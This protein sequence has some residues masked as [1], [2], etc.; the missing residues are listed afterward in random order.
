[1]LQLL[2]DA[3]AV[4]LRACDER[5]EE[6]RCLR[7][8]FD[9]AALT[10]VP[11]RDLL[12]LPEDAGLQ[13]IC[14]VLGILAME[15][16]SYLVLILDQRHVATIGDDGKVWQLLRVVLLPLHHDRCVAALSAVKDASPPKKGAENGSHVSVLRKAA[17]SVAH[18]VQTTITGSLE[19]SLGSLGLIKQQHATIERAVV[20]EL[21]RTLSSGTFYVSYNADI[22][23]SLGHRTRDETLSWDKLEQK[24]VWNM[25]LA[26]PFLQASLG[27]WV[28]PVVQGYFETVPC[29]VDSITFNLSLCSRRSRERAGFRYQR[30]G[31]DANN[32]NANFVETEQILAV[33]INGQQ[34][35]MC[36]LQVR[37]SIPLFWS[38][39]ARSLKPLPV[40]E[41]SA[42]EN[43]DAMKHHFRRLAKE[44]DGPVRAINLV[45]T[46]G[47]EAVIGSAYRETLGECAMD[48]VQ[49]IEFDFHHE[50]RGMLFGNVQRLVSRLEQDLEQIGYL[51]V[52]GAGNVLCRQQGIMRSNCMD[53]LDR[54]NVVQSALARH[55]IGLQ[56]M[57]LGILA[58]KDPRQGSFEQTFNILWANNGDKIAEAYTGTGALKGDFT[59]TGMR[60]LRGVA[61]DASNSL[62]RYYV[63]NF[64]DAYRQDV[65]DV[66]LG[67]KP[68][69]ELYVSPAK[70]T[71]DVEE[72]DSTARCRDAALDAAEYVLW[73]AESNLGAWIVAELS[74]EKG[75]DPD[76]PEKVMVLSDKALYLC[77]YNYAKEYIETSTRV[78]YT[79]VV[80]LQRGYA[81]D[82]G[83]RRESAGPMCIRV[84][85]QNTDAAAKAKE[86]VL[87]ILYTTPLSLSPPDQS[88]LPVRV[89]DITSAA[90]SPS[91]ATGTELDHERRGHSTAQVNLVLQLVREQIRA[92]TR[93][94]QDILLDEDIILP[95]SIKAQS[96]SKS[97]FPAIPIKS[98]ITGLVSSLSLRPS[99]AK[100][101]SDTP[102]SS[103]SASASRPS[104][105]QDVIQMKSVGTGSGPV[106]IAWRTARHASTQADALA[107]LRLLS[108]LK[109]Q[110]PYSLLGVAPSATANDIKQAF[111]GRVLALHPDRLM[112]KEL[113]ER[114]EDKLRAQYDGVNLAYE[115]LSSAPLRKLY[116]R[117][118][119]HGTSSFRAP[120]SSQASRYAAHGPTYAGAYNPDPMYFYYNK[121]YGSRVHG[122]A[123]AAEEE[124]VMMGGKP[125]LPNVLVVSGV[126]LFAFA[127]TSLQ[128]WRFR[129]GSKIVQDTLDRESGVAVEALNNVRLKASQRSAAEFHASLRRHNQEVQR[130]REQGKLP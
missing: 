5:T 70:A 14:G 83:D 92:A 108:Q 43:A 60:N 124:P 80:Q 98:A 7:V 58:E 22:S 91:G 76:R 73:P 56:L 67:N 112:H 54:T 127:G 74:T 8:S 45:E 28:H 104:S 88:P 24:F 64:K 122:D 42:V 2:V 93:A 34:H 63:N 105:P 126:L 46:A 53:C 114:E 32:G 39:T 21:E 90:V 41:K 118:V 61:R 120:S 85:Y 52:D 33:E 71:V 38:Q 10:E 50:C 27:G 86:F 11:R 97:P 111:R 59:R 15:L 87:Q 113:S 51:W 25:S 57:R 106:S 119:L 48:N 116:D 19:T 55:V 47:K 13:Q 40:L 128:Y 69:S 82:S 121:Y 102:S 31:M 65:L 29:L 103:R 110:S 94:N 115:I 100:P 68:A 3:D 18:T 17:L 79:H 99:A 125:R 72:V 12:L 6:S 96:R 37:G 107:D 23:R 129:N 66:F 77:R 36:F 78:D 109:G 9:A 123:A 101:S 35:L 49:Y 30:R 16:D 130:L 26:E 62:T 20:A 84:V 44:Y 81:I 4:Y 95:S 1:M 75:R 89:A 117:S